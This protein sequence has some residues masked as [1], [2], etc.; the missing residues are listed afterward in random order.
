MRIDHPQQLVLPLENAAPQPCITSD[1]AL[2]AEYEVREVIW[3]LTGE[4]F[5]ARF[6]VEAVGERAFSY[7]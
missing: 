3:P 4:R 6:P 7:A 1:A 5:M 2:L